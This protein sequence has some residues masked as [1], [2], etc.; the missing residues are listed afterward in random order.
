LELRNG[1][2]AEQFMVVVDG[3]VQDRQRVRT[4]EPGSAMDRWIQEDRF[5]YGSDSGDDEG[6]P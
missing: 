1:M 4:A 5:N 2:Q 6:S 3:F